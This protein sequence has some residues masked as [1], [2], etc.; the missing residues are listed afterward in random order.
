MSTQ[1]VEKT[2]GLE[3]SGLPVEVGRVAGFLASGFSSFVHGA[4]ILV[5]GGST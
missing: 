3:R 1:A 2:N 4:S 5:D